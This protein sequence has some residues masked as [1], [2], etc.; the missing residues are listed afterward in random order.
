M[1]H[2]AINEAG[3]KLTSHAVDMSID[4]GKV[5]SVDIHVPGPGWQLS[6][7]FVPKVMSQCP[8]PGCAVAPRHQA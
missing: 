1:A 4:A 8:T 6:Y 7:E 2:N 5:L 3:G